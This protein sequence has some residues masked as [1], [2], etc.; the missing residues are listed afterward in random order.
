MPPPAADPA[1]GLIIMEVPPATDRIWLRRT[2]LP[3][4][5]QGRQVTLLASGFWFLSAFAAFAR[6]SPP[7]PAVRSLARHLSG[8]GRR[9]AG[10]TQV[11]KETVL[12]DTA[13]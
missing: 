9:S 2:E 4:D 6:V 12:S 5:R 8:P 13:V 7:F 10:T 11:D 3:E 1:T